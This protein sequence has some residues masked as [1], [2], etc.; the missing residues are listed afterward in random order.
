MKNA[1]EIFIGIIYTIFI[2]VMWY[3]Q[4]YICAEADY[5]NGKWDTPKAIDVYQGK[6][7]LQYTMMNGEKV[8]S[9]VVFKK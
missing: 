7:T 1:L 4:G 8:D 6:T 5:N 9:I 3:C 2:S